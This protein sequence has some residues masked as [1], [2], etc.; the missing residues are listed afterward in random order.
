GL[1]ICDS[2]FD[3][4]ALAVVDGDESP[5]TLETSS[6]L[7][8]ALYEC[9]A[10]CRVDERV[11]G[12]ECVACAPGKTNPRG[13]DPRLGGIETTC[14]ATLC[15]VDEYVVNHAC[16]SCAAGRYSLG[17]DASLA[18]NTEC[19]LCTS[20][21]GC[22]QDV[23]GAC[24][25]SGDV[26]H[27]AC[28]QAGPGFYIVGNGTDAIATPCNDMA[29]V[30]TVGSCTSCSG[31]AVEQCS[32]GRCAP[33]FFRFVPGNGTTAP[34]CTPS[35]P[36]G[37]DE[38]VVAHVCTG[39]PAGKTNDAGDS[40]LDEDTQC[41]ELRCALNEFVKSNLCLPCAEGYENAA[42]DPRSGPDTECERPAISGMCAGNTASS[43]DV[44]CPPGQIRKMDAAATSGS[45]VA[46]CCDARTAE[47]TEL[48]AW[49]ATPFGACSATCG[50]RDAATRTVTC[51]KIE[52]FENGLVSRTPADAESRCEP[53][54]RPPASK[55]CPRLATGSPCDDSNPETMG[56]ACDSADVCAG[57]V[58]LVAAVTFDIA[59]DAAALSA[60]GIDDADSSPIAASAKG[61]LATTLSAG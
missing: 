36:C 44:A 15:A 27:L 53:G 55:P 46:D 5:R 24:L 42:G 41:T 32:M 2:E 3:E 51:D 22:A 52:V 49:R 45:T 56:D 21:P 1:A 28:A 6:P 10:T 29:T 43:S 13:D 35:T 12:G 34:R 39:C 57:K 14:N 7:L 59:I 25:T 50:D 30:E 38:R 4:Y 54:E 58:A 9:D 40:P 33:G 17:F 26:Q 18:P 19:D 47:P 37:A 23:P 60:I 48:Y 20:Q 16:A 11:S 8:V 31:P 61:L